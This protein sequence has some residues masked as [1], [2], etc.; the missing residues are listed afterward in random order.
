M[1]DQKVQF[2]TFAGKES[3]QPKP[4]SLTWARLVGLLVAHKPRA[5]KDGQLWTPGTY[6]VGATRGND[7]VIDL[8]CFVA[9]VDDGTPV[10]TLRERWKAMDGQ[11]LAF[12]LYSSWSSSQEKPRWRVVFPFAAPVKAEDWPDIW[13]RCSLYLMGNHND[14]TAKDPARIYYLPSC[15][16]ESLAEAFAD[17][18]DGVFLD[19][20]SLPAVEIP[21]PKPRVVTP[22]ISAGLLCDTDV[23]AKAFT[24][25]NSAKFAALWSGDTSGYGGDQSRADEALCTMLAFWCGPAGY[26]QVDR[27]FRQSG[28]YRDKWN[29]E[30]YAERTIERAIETCREFY[31]PGV[32]ESPPPHSDTDA[33]PPRSG[34]GFALQ[35]DEQMRYRNSDSG[36]ADR[37]V[38]QHGSDVRC[39]HVK[40]VWHVWDG[41]RWREDNSKTVQEKAIATVVN[42]YAEAFKETDEARRKALGDHA[43]V[44]D[45]ASRIAAILTLAG[46]NPEIAVTPS[47]WDSDPF[48]LNC[49]NG[50]VDLRTGCLR[51]HE[52]KDHIT[53]ICTVDYDPDAPCPLWLQC[54]ERWQPDE[55]IRSFL[56]RAAG[57]SLT[58]DIG[59]ET[60]FFLYGVG[61][62]GK[63]K[64]TSAM[65]MI[66]GDYAA[67]VSVEALMESHKGAA[68]TPEIVP[69]VN[70]R[71][72]IASE[73]A[74]GRR[75]N[76]A[77]LK[78]VT[79]GDAITCT[80]KYGHTFRFTPSFKLWFY[81]NHKPTIRGT[82][83]G[84]WSR[85]PLV[86]FTITIPASERDPELS[87]KLWQEAPGILA[88]M[89]RGCR[90]WQKHRLSPPDAVIEATQ[91][92]R[93][94]MDTLAGFWE[95]CC[96][97]HPKAWC[98]ANSLRDGYLKW[99]E[100]EK[101]KFPLSTPLFAERLKQKQATQDKRRFNGAVVRGWSGVAL[102]SDQQE[103]DD[104]QLTP[105]ETTKNEAQNS[106]CVR[107]DGFGT[108]FP[109]FSHVG[110]L[111]NFTKSASTPV[112]TA[113][114]YI[115]TSTSIQDKEEKIE[116]EDNTSV[117][118][119][120]DLPDPFSEE[121]EA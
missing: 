82:D 70:A 94:E 21:K 100:A 80:P 29:R 54:L 30:D 101:V 46:S 60:A 85:L 45:K 48:L 40:N 56:Q 63:S 44:S 12:V 69:L 14:Q 116:K 61:R 95:K 91:E 58:G 73:I 41:K 78:D 104:F 92:F 75:I 103:P 118:D 15:P 120:D 99:C 1:T 42:I 51:A 89:V 87:A 76:E 36:N 31:S 11:S 13:R 57:Y 47:L 52:R 34:R 33:P 55:K 17:A 37:F 79:G 64:F 88:W 24:A 5:E 109:D 84:I 121:E 114:P 59:E 117:P 27:L 8:Y 119:P 18:D 97:F 50:T 62:N 102:K 4:G 20:Y 23:I 53:R 72:V 90:E 71:L 35:P 112:N 10:S 7:G 2:V 39:D 96:V 83:D 65:E 93:D 32:R 16:P 49:Q 38:D 107:V 28:L 113:T 115:S 110:A 25:R 26:D 9:D 77:L 98:T 68:N 6:S 43:K 106:E 81:G 86:P 105:P 3:R 66:L 22:G 108:D 19:P 67:R 111:K 74:E